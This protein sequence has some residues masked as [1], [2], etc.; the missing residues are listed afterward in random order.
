MS[1]LL[2][3]KDANYS[4]E[5]NI[6]MLYFYHEYTH[7]HAQV[8]T[9]PQFG[10]PSPNSGPAVDS[11]KGQSGRQRVT[12]PG[13]NPV[14]DYGQHTAM[15]PLNSKMKLRGEKERALPGSPQCAGSDFLPM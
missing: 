8:P 9:K 5:R 4:E 1:F 2:K 10:F 13:E 14:M 12:H 11:W 6:Q 15:C 7:G 3:E